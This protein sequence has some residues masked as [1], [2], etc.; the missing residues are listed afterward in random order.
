MKAVI[1][2]WL[3]FAFLSALFVAPLTATARAGDLPEELRAA[4]A[5][6]CLGGLPGSGGDDDTPCQTMACHALSARRDKIQKGSG[7]A[8]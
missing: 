2:E 5:F 3:I 8:C 4:I 1:A 7:H 6:T